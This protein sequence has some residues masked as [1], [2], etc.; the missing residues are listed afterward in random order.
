MKTDSTYSITSYQGGSL[1]KPAVN[2][3]MSF[4]RETTGTIKIIIPFKNLHKGL[5]KEMVYDWVE[6]GNRTL[7]KAEIEEVETNLKNTQRG[8][9]GDI[10]ELLDG[11]KFYLRK[12]GHCR[13]D[14]KAVAI[15][16]LLRASNT[17]SATL[18]VIKG[19]PR[20]GCRAIEPK[21]QW[22]VCTR[23]FVDE[24]GVTLE[25]RL[26]EAIESY[27]EPKKDDK[28]NAF[29]ISYKSSN[30]VSGHHKLAVLSFY[31]YLWMPRYKDLVK[32]VLKM[33]KWGVTPWDAL[34]LEHTRGSYYYYYG[35]TTSDFRG[36]P[37]MK[38][39]LNNFKAG[40]SI[41]ESFSSALGV[42]RPYNFG[43]LTKENV[44]KALEHYSK[45]EK[46]IVAAVVKCISPVGKFLTKNKNYS[47]DG[48]THTCFKINNDGWC[49]KW[50]SKDRF[51]IVE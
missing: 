20:N 31:R 25:V 22:N 24:D 42:V 3:C 30:C 5:T 41:N 9:D 13:S 48:V 34:M 11:V 51:K 4:I 18:E 14:A 21:T 2:G 32:N 38:S 7:F 47:V 26:K 43:R 27:K 49:W 33:I 17:T 19:N 16:S 46:I 23:D 39:V 50:Y 36:I 37:S 8:I 44:Q 15:G 35:F 12:N 28:N 40:R 10:I 1:E 6:I 29:C 45:D